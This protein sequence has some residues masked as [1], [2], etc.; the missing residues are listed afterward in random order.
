ALRGAHIDISL[1]RTSNDGSEARAMNISRLMVFLVALCSASN[2]RAQT[3]DDSKIDL[4]GLVRPR[5]LFD[6]AQNTS[7]VPQSPQAHPAAFT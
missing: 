1:W 5:A 2:L 6:I 7:A 4:E 3:P